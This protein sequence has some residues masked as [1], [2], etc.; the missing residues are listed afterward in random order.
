MGAGQ[1]SRSKDNL[2]LKY[3]EY[4]TVM[5]WTDRQFNVIWK[6]L[7]SDIKACD[8]IIKR[9]QEALAFRNSKLS[10]QQRRSFEV[11]VENR[12]KY[13]AECQKRQE[14]LRQITKRIAQRR[15][16]VRY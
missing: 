11:L 12:T 13:K 2:D 9:Q 6:M 4:N 15:Q 1:R 5:N 16:R 10:Q 7:S 3:Y 14:E 8:I